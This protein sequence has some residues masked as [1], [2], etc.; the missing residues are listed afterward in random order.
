MEKT[1]RQNECACSHEQMSPR[2]HSGKM[3]AHAQQI[4]YSSENRLRMLHFSI[5]FTPV[6][7]IF[8]FCLIRYVMEEVRRN[9]S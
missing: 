2:G 3:S 9:L 5:K 6:T 4:F 1:Q 7:I 8:F